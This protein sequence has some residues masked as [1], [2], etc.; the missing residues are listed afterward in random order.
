MDANLFII[1]LIISILFVY[2]LY[3]E[4]KE[5]EHAYIRGKASPND[6]VK[7]SLKKIDICLSYD[8]KTIKWRRC[9]I[10]T[11]VIMFLLFVFVRDNSV[12]SKN[13]LLHFTI[14]FSLTYIMWRN[15]ASVT[16]EDVHKIGMQNINNI[17]KRKKSND[18][19]DFKV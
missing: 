8:L 3:F 15:Y 11:V 18:E 17:L 10:S 16:G 19:K 12:S 7:K 14:I 9:L 13:I 4:I 6:N 1:L 5:Q 2:A